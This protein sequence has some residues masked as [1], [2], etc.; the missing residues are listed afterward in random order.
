MLL[1]QILQPRLITDV[2]DTGFHGQENFKTMIQF[3]NYQ[4]LPHILGDEGFY[5]L[6]DG[7]KSRSAHE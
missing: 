5:Q 1:P 7:P 4:A 2:Y 3:P 6:L